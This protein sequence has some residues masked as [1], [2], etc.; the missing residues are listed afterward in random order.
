MIKPA[1][2]KRGDKVATIS[3]SWG[4]AGEI[5][6][7]YNIGKKQL[8]ET[9][10]VEVVETKNALKSADWIYNNPQARAQDLMEALEDKS[11]KAIISNI[12][13]D[14]SIRILPY[15]DLAV[16]KNNPKIFLGYSDS[17]V[18]HFC[19]LKAGVTSYY[20]TSLLVGF[21]ENNGLHQYQI[22]DI[23][24]T[25]FDSNE[26]GNIKP[27]LDGW[28][29]ERIPWANPDN[30]KISRKLEKN[31]G[32]RFLQGK[33]RFE[34]ELLGG[35][36]DVLE[37]I[38]DTSIWVEPKDWK[39]KIMF[40]ETS[41]SQMPPSRFC[42][43]LR[44]YAASGILKNINGLILGRPD[45]NR[46]WSEYDNMLLKVIQT[47][48]GLTELPIIS[49]MDFGHTCPVFTLPYGVN[50]ELDIDKETF[51]ILESGVVD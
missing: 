42:K 12:G 49:G 38:K 51:R 2:L 13:G 45:N 25:L 26:I 15:I 23:Q 29:S 37:V 3:M 11:I 10:G 1:K 46:Y 36:M 30:H 24:K 6:H 48:E 4:G 34:G 17:T 22:M 50:A 8:E 7:R 14:D 18:T 21:A 43:I 41:E 28:T 47:E 39:N 31:A 35:C 9:F 32:W 40:L 44:N 5:L 33:G 16:I 19:F 20:G 27:N